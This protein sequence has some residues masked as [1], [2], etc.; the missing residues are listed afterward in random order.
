MTKVLM[1]G[2]EAL[3]EAALLAGCKYYFGSPVTPQ[4]ELPSYLAKRMPQ[5][6]GV[7]SQAESEISAINMVYGAA[8]AGARVLTSN[9]GP[10]VSA[11]QEGIAYT[12]SAELPCVIVNIMKGGPGSNNDNPSQS[13]Y[14]QATKGHGDYKTIVYA[15]ASVQ[16]M[17][18]FT[19]SAFDYA[20]K[21]RNPVIILADGIVDSMMEPV[22]L[23]KPYEYDIDSKEW[24]LGSAS[25]HRNICAALLEDSQEQEVKNWALYQ[26][27][28][29]I[30]EYFADKQELSV[31]EY[32]CDDADII[33]V[34]YGIIARVLKTVV[35]K[36]R[37]R[38]IRAGLARPKILWPFPSEAIRRL[39]DKTALFMV[40]EMSY[41]QMVEDVKIAVNGKKPVYFF[42]RTGGSVPSDFEILGEVQKLVN[43][44]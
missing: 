6:G 5:V 28:Q 22:E 16:E 31:E 3:G 32:M 19:M 40:V 29:E 34:G 4:S 37:K 11:K 24:A 12:A 26:K 18:D 27:Y 17:A 36:C 41:G 44:D 35:E 2:S 9:S 25:N 39:A 8:S 43:P 30:A 15:P 20:D 21:F 10:N 42:G 14:W 23:P 13:D 1:K 33:L 38:G 7:F